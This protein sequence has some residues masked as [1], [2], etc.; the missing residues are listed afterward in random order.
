MMNHNGDEY[1][2]RIYIYN[3]YYIYIYV[4]VNHFAV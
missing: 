1:V 2:E 4:K 3:V